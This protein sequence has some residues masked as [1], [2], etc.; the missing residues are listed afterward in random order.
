[1]DLEKRIRK[2]IFNIGNN[3]YISLKTI[4]KLNDKGYDEVSIRLHKKGRYYT[5]VNDKYLHDMFFDIYRM[6]SSIM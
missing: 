5:R 1:M 3:Q 2:V 6:N 4:Y